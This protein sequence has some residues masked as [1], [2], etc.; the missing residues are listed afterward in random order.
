MVVGKGFQEL[1]MDE[2]QK[3]LVVGRAPSRAQKLNSTEEKTSDDVKLVAGSRQKE[4]NK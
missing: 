2:I 1:E 3:K 4:I